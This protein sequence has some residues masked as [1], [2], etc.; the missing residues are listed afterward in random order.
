MIGILIPNN[1]WFCPY[2]GIY[3]NI[4]DYEGVPYE[5]V[6]WCRDGKIEMGCIQYKDSNTY[7]NIVSRLLSY[8]RYSLFVRKSV[9]HK[10][11]EKLIVFTPQLAIFLAGFLRRHYRGRY[12]FDYRDL[13]IE[14][15]FIFKKP[16]LTVLNN[17]AVNVISSPGFR[18]YLPPGYD[19]VLS[20]N[21]N[22]NKV[23]Q[24]LNSAD[25]TLPPTL[26]LESIDVLTIGGIRDYDSN[27]QGIDSL[28]NK[29]GFKVRFIG[30]G[31]SATALQTHA[32]S[33]GAHNVLFEGFY[34]KENEAAYIEGCTF[35]NIFYPRLNSHDTALSNRFYNSLI[36]KK[37]MITT[38]DTTQGDYARDYS[39]GVAIEDCDN[40]DLILK[41][42]LSQMDSELYVQRCNELLSSFVADYE[43]FECLVKQFVS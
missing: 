43:K 3:T 41:D 23:R 33:I 19:Y 38:A 35:M 39:L 22:I 24:V 2:V 25:N 6:S 21:F 5:I 34:P 32:E 36:Y 11:Y 26:S 13:S 27:V 28:S 37:P 8:Y 17:S 9:K 20:H 16:F 18:E 30:R 10:K 42:F 29:K 7:S 12:I 40:L 1:L 31:P 15:H 14:Q 4:L